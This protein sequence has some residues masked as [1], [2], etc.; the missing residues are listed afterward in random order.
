MD[1]RN[2]MR[3]RIWLYT[4]LLL[5]T[6]HMMANSV[7]FNSFWQKAQEEERT[8]RYLDACKTY[9]KILDCQDSI[10]NRTYSKTIEDLS[11]IYRVEGLKR[12]SDKF[13]AKI[14]F[15]SALSTLILCAVFFSWTFRFEKGE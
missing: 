14:I 1:C 12:E 7:H 15:Y 9:Q 5:F 10:Y 11:S 4:L 8:G 2:F 13:K 6:S 3:R